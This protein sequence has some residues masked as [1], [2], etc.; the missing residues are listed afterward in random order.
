ML[1]FAFYFVCGLLIFSIT[2]IAVLILS[3]MIIEKWGDLKNTIAEYKKEKQW[4]KK[5]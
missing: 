1:E 4:E 3:E 5:N 2:C